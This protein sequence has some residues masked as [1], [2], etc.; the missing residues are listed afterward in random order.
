MQTG[1][2]QDS[3]TADRGESNPFGPPRPLTETC[4]SRRFIELIGNK[5]ILLILMALRTGPRRNGELKREIEG[6]SQKV[7][8]Q[9]LRR[10]EANG[11]VQ[12]KDLDTSPPHVEYSLTE[13]GGSLENVMRRLDDWFDDHLLSFSR[14][15]EKGPK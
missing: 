8:T 10:L 7:L 9:A 11:L 6:I 14:S 4:T 3:T 13:L 12:R 15:Q 2:F 1:D 5:W